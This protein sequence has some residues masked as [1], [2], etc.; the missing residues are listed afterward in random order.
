MIDTFPT[1]LLS[2][3]ALLFVGFIVTIVLVYV[4]PRSRR[5]D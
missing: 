2:G 1:E 5:H 4:S 3:S